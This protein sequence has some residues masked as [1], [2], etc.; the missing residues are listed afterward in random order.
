MY[1]LVPYLIPSSAA[2]TKEEQS[3]SYRPEE[4]ATGR[5]PYL[6]RFWVEPYL[7]L[8]RLV[9]QSLTSPSSLAMEAAEL[10]TGFSGAP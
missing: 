8:V 10:V 3:I 5:E 2:C 9:I 6:K 4:S 7:S 1:T